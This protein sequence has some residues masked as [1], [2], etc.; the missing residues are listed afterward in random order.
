[1]GESTKERKRSRSRDNKD[2]KRQNRSR[3]RS[4]HNKQSDRSRGTEQNTR[5][6]K[7]KNGIQTVEFYEEKTVDPKKTERFDE[8]DLIS[9]LKE[10]VNFLTL[11]YNKRQQEEKAKAAAAAAAAKAA[12][13]PERKRPVLDLFNPASGRAGG[14]YVPPY[15]LR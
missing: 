13:E 7:D 12:E 2:S 5:P 14:V 6:K 15:K 11:E 8:S 4:V 9:S 3:S 1:M 10:D